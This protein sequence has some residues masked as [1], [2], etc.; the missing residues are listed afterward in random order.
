MSRVYMKDAK[1]AVIGLSCQASWENFGRVK[2]RDLLMLNI[3]K[4][5][6]LGAIAAAPAVMEA[7]RGLT[8]LRRLRRLQRARRP[9]WRWRW[10]WLT[11]TVPA[12]FWLADAGRL[13]WRL[14]G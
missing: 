2:G 14:A 8:H 7:V 1:L 9:G 4:P 5:I 6:I 13:L 3:L 12:L 11:T 10:L